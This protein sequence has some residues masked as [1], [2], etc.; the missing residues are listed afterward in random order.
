VQT[1]QFIR[2]AVRFEQ[3]R[4]DRDIK[5]TRRLDGLERRVAF[6]GFVGR[7][8]LLE[9]RLGVGGSDTRT[10]EQERE[11]RV[12]LV[13]VHESGDAGMRHG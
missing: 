12:H 10:G 11:R 9:Q 13:R 6:Q 5:E 8:H 4:G 3:I 2:R 1:G 7:T